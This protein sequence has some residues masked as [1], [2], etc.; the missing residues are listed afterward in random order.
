MHPIHLSV[1]VLALIA[2]GAALV[3]AGF[4]KAEKSIA[5]NCA[6]SPILVNSC[7]PW[8]S[9]TAGGYAMTSSNDQFNFFNKRLNNPSVLTNPSAG[10]NV[11]Y[12]MDVPHVYHQGGQALFNNNAR[13]I[14]SNTA[15]YSDPNNPLLVNWK[16]GDKWGATANGSADATIIE[17][18]KAVKALGSR[19]IF[20]TLW[21]EPENHGDVSPEGITFTSNCKRPDGNRGSA[22]EYRAMWKHVREVFDQQGVTNVVWFWNL[23]GYVG[24]NA[25]DCLVKPLYPGNQYVDWV[26][27][28]PYSP[29]GNFVDSVSRFYNFLSVNTDG[30]Y[31][32]KSKPWGLAE[33]GSNSEPNETVNYWQ[34]AKAAIGTSWA[35][36]KFP[37]IKLW[38]VF[39]TA[40]NGGTN[41]GLR[42]GYN[43]LGNVDTTEQAAFNGFAKTILE[44]SDGGTAPPPPPSKDTAPPAVALTTPA[45]GSR[46]A[47]IITI[48]GNATDNVKVTAVT[49]RVNDKYIATDNTAPYEFKLDTRKY[50]EGKHSIVL[51]AWDA[52]DNMGQS[53]TAVITIDNH[54]GKDEQKTP[55]P[56]SSTVI[57]STTGSSEAK[58]IKTNGTLIISPTA[59]GNSIQVWVNDKLQDSNIIDTVN[60]TNGTHIIKIAE[61]GAISYKLVSVTNPLP[62]AMINHARVNAV[63]YLILFAASG[64]AL[65]LWVGRTYVLGLTSR[66][67]QS[68]I[69]RQRRIN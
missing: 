47:G 51:R 20:L 16:P 27:W 54:R 24:N 31:N 10:T 46:N 53:K 41:G 3:L 23:T 9:A 52:A 25:W 18:A 36:N 50:K 68:I 19:K 28:D 5:A 15:L 42:V 55:P 39:D 40:S 67:E 57:T 35:T 56:S 60:L 30:T 17:S 59:A 7:R 38:S 26:M 37:N 6:I 8:L 1:V 62:I 34:E 21:H 49:L 33:F 63:T 44:F 11:A 58:P 22:A 13:Q 43:N 32:F 45:D 12:K 2:F 61:N 29:G 65:V 64:G 66:R 48:R 69:R 14:L 4:G